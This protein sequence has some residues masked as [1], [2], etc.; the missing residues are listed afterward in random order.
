MKPICPLCNNKISD[1]TYIWVD[2][3]QRLIH[4]VCKIINTE[5]RKDVTIQVGPARMGTKIRR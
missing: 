5:M 2:A 1:N 3:E 4:K